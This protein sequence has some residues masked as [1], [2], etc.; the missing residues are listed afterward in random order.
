MHIVKC[1]ENFITPMIKKLFEYLYRVIS[2]TEIYMCLL[3]Y[4]SITNCNIS[5]THQ[6]N[7]HPYDVFSLVTE[8]KYCS[9]YNF[10]KR[11][12]LD[13][14]LQFSKFNVVFTRVLTTAVCQEN[15]DFRELDC[16]GVLDCWK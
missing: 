3:I 13:T 9:S 15:A 5:V 12:Q 11:Q 10:T 7:A 16:T 6:K 4:P 14:G 2:Y 1:K 8:I